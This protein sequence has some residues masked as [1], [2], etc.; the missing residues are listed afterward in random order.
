MKVACLQLDARGTQTSLEDHL[1]AAVAGWQ[2]VDA[3]LIVLPE[4][5]A[6]G[7]FA[8]HRHAE[9][10]DNAD[11]ILEAMVALAR[12]RCA[13]VVG[14]SQ[15]ERGA[16][17]VLH[18]TSTVI[19]PY[20]VP[21]GAYRKMHLYGHGFGES[22]A[23]AA[24]DTVA[25]VRLGDLVGGLAICYDLRFPELYRAQVAAGATV[26]ITVAAWPA[27]KSRAWE[28]LHV[29]RAI[30]NQSYVIACN[31]CGD[32]EG[33]PLAGRSLVVSPDGTV[34]AR[35]GTGPE[36]L[37]VEIDPEVVRRARSGFPVLGD[38]RLRVALPPGISQSTV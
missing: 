27:A 1:A 38:R 26:L 31:G 24:G 9:D 35:A 20:G 14:G 7:F 19:D 15:V 3:D 23:F 16:T 5:W 28:A 17:G 37:A 32:D 8:E 11:M 13:W 33:V 29:A 10:A 25:C 30:E 34:V 12:E 21:R 2:N 18:N 36:Q 6:S 22:R 4:L